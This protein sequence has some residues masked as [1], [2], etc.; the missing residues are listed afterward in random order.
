MCS[1]GEWN[2][3]DIKTGCG[4]R[5][6]A[7]N[8]YGS[9]AMTLGDISDK[10]M[11]GS[12]RVGL[13]YSTHVPYSP[14]TGHLGLS[15][16]TRLK[17]DEQSMMFN[18]ILD[19]TGSVGIEGKFGGN[20]YNWQEPWNYGAG[21]YG[22]HDLVGGTGTTAGL[23]GNVGLLSGKVGYNPKTGAEA[24]IGFGLPIRQD[25]EEIIQ[26]GMLPEI[27][28]SA[29][30]DQTYN[31]LS[32]PQ[33]NL[34]DTFV[35]PDG[36]A[37][38][39]DIGNSY[40]DKRQMH[41]KDALRM[42]DDLGVRNISNEPNLLGQMFPKAFS[43]RD[44]N[45]FRPHAN[46]ILKNIHVPKM[47]KPGD[48][49][50]RDWTDHLVEDLKLG[51]KYWV[52]QMTEQ[53][54]VDKIK[55]FRKSVED[56]YRSRYFSD[57]IAEFAHIPEFWRSESFYNIPKSFMNDAMRF[58][59]GKEMDHSRYH[60]KDH[61]EYKTHN[62][63][64]SFENQLRE[65]YKLQ[66]GGSLPK[67]QNGEEPIYG[68]LLPEVEVSALTD[69]TYNTLSDPLKQ[70]YNT[71]VN[72]DGSV[73]QTVDI[74]DYSRTWSTK[75]EG[76]RLMHW[77]GALQMTEDL[78]IKNIHNTPYETPGWFF[79]LNEG[80]TNYPIDKDGNFRPH[81]MTG[82]KDIHMP[83]Y[84][85]KNS[86]RGWMENH[87]KNKREDG[88]GI[89]DFENMLDDTNLT[90]EEK[91][92]IIQQFSNSRSAEKDLE[93]WEK[94]FRDN[95]G[96]GEGRQVYFDDLIAESAHIPEYGRINSLWNRPIA[97]LKRAYRG[98][99]EGK[100][101][102]NS[103]Y[104]DPHDYEYKTHTGPDSFEEK[105][106]SKYEIK[107][108]G[109]SLPEAQDGTETERQKYIQFALD[110]ESGYDYI[111]AKDSAIKK[112]GADGKW[113]G[114]TYYKIFEDGKYY[115]HY[116]N[117]E[118]RA[119]IG[120]GHNPVDRDILDE[121]KDGINETQALDLLDDD[122]DEKLR[123][124]EIY[125]NQRFGDNKWNDL[126]ESEKFML[127]DYTFNVKGG[128]HKTFKN[129]A[130]AIHDKDFKSANKEYKRKLGER[131]SIFM[132]AYL[133]PWMD[134]QKE[135]VAV[136]PP[137]EDMPLPIGTHLMDMTEPELE[138]KET[139]WWRGEE[140]FIPDELELPW[141]M[142]GAGVNAKGSGAS[143]AIDIPDGGA[144]E[145]AAMTRTAMPQMP[146]L[147]NDLT[148]NDNLALS[149]TIADLGEDTPIAKYGGQYMWGL[150]LRSTKAK[151][152]KET[153]SDDIY[154]N[155]RYSQSASKYKK[156]VPK[157]QDG[158]SLP[159]AQDGGLDRAYGERKN[160]GILHLIELDMQ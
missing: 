48:P 40:E 157:Y 119:T 123:L 53:E 158:G 136:A 72:P 51:E 11:S 7:H 65:K 28:V 13:G 112:L 68:G 82:D 155:D 108:Q 88:V 150:D 154:A 30:T 43:Y 47:I 134:V 56:V 25:G 32:Q 21:I 83:A 86:R 66:D 160:Y 96:P 44:K 144:A 109:G 99:K 90:P 103:N 71:F 26:G 41:W 22:R 121:Y 129:F 49:E 24:T 42:T 63:A 74:G 148:I 35:T 151:A 29:L 118:K 17:G 75:D 55:V 143:S 52:K 147:N 159:K 97:N 95:R 59:Q 54:R 117:D 146:S 105:L 81:I 79:G 130:K 84:N 3:K 156:M 138:K 8:L 142:D 67:A 141:F 104:K 124:S 98:I 78:G 153:K 39:V 152:G 87:I 100:W 61:Y 85:T 107:K 1:N 106:R 20:S 18:P 111:R 139:S 4:T 110:T 140:G 14:I 137:L 89:W 64:D 80:S 58:I 120:H 31:T 46:S 45:D 127:N 60:D 10:S 50:Y 19:A 101:P 132:D 76:N 69:K 27:E 131:N 122:V 57:M 126:T 6:S 135:K 113:D 77:K 16:G 36:I 145:N 2:G 73:S 128:F 92:S 33:Q 114:K 125:Y 15:G 12:A 62:A 115:P 70:V 5:D 102:D 91:E 93:L 94:T 149:N 23:Y 133:K 37:Q 34:Y 38:T 9:G 116:V